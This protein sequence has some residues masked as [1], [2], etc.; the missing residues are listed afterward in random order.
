MSIS[1]PSSS[2]K[3]THTPLSTPNQAPLYPYLNRSSSVGS[4]LAITIFATTTA[5]YTTAGKTPNASAIHASSPP[6]FT[7]AS[8]PATA[9]RATSAAF[10]PGR[11]SSKGPPATWRCGLATE[12]LAE[13]SS[14]R[15]KPSIAAGRGGVLPLPLLAISLSFLGLVLLV[16]L[17]FALASRSSAGNPV[18]PVGRPDR[19]HVEQSSEEMLSIARRG[20]GDGEGERSAR[21]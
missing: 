16:A 5:V 1:H 10:K 9:S 4:T 13:G 18:V 11:Y 7:D 15:P 12:L 17:A 3:T 2:Y 21:R 19:V 8:T 14:S 20:D 6:S